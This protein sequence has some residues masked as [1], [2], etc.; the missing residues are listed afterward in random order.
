[1]PYPEKSRS[2]LLKIYNLGGKIEKIWE[3]SHIVAEREWYGLFLVRVDIAREMN[4]L[5]WKCFVSQNIGKWRAT[6]KKRIRNA[7]S[8][9]SIPCYTLSANCF[10]AWNKLVCRRVTW[11]NVAQNRANSIAHLARFRFLWTMR[12]IRWFLKHRHCDWPRCRERAVAGAVLGMVQFI[13]M[14]KRHINKVYGFD[15]N[16]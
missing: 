10:S 3:T 14:Y 6:K 7:S 11:F 4:L 15:I 9:Y 2:M 5:I 13:L 16:R 8:F 12:I 1:M